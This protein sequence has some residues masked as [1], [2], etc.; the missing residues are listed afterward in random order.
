MIVFSVLLGLVLTNVQAEEKYDRFEKIQN[1][2]LQ[3]GKEGSQ[4]HFRAFTKM[5]VPLATESAL[6]ELLDFETSC[7][8][9]LAHKRNHLTRDHHCKRFDRD[10]IENIVIKKLKTPD[11]METDE[12]RRLLVGRR[13]YNRGEYS[14]YELVRVFKKPDGYRVTLELLKDKAAREF[15][16]PKL[17]FDYFF[18]QKN[19]EYILTKKSDSVSELKLITEAST[20]NWF[21]NKAFSVGQVFQGLVTETGDVIGRFTSEAQKSDTKRS[22]ASKRK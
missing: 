19:T 10:V 1:V 9:D 3:T 21:L 6:E 16:D 4:R 20:R 18:H 14:Y 12:V 15:L 22:F 11:S 8:N 13:I 5:D 2:T 7:N 17:K